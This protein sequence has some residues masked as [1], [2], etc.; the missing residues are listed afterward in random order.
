VMRRCTNRGRYS[1]EPLSAEVQQSILA[2]NDDSPNVDVSILTRSKKDTCLRILHDL[3]RLSMGNWLLVREVMPYVRTDLADIEA[4]RDRLDI[5][6]LEL[7]P[8]AVRLA[9]LSKR[10]PTFFGWFIAFFSLFVAGQVQ[11]RLARTWAESGAL[12]VFSI[13]DRSQ[14]SYVSLGR[15]VQRILNS[16]TAQN[17]QTFTVVNGLYLF[18]LLKENLEIYSNSDQRAL[19]RYQYELQSFLGFGDRRLALFV[20]AGYGEAPA[21]RARRRPVK[22]FFIDDLGNEVRV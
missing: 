15:V 12:L 2:A 8:F 22:S 7:G 4:H 3:E 13:R 16:L 5:R 18:E 1:A 9:A 10:Y 17:V 19:L 21:V 11:R 6:T 20:R 14:H